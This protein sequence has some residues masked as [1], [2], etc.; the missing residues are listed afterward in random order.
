MKKITKQFYLDKNDGLLSYKNPLS[1]DICW[2]LLSC[3]QYVQVHS[4]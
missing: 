1:L 2:Q 4:C 3:S